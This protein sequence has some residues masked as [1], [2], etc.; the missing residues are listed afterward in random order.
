LVVDCVFDVCCCC[1][2]V[3]GAH[4]VFVV[5]EYL[6]VDIVFGECFGEC[7][8]G[9]VVLVFDGGWF[10]GVCEVYAELV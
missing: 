3:V 5:V 6:D 8:D 9:V 2:V 4:G 10:F 7:R 1:C